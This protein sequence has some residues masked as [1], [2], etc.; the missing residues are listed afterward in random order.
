LVETPSEYCIEELAPEID[1]GLWDNTDDQEYCV[2]AVD[3]LR[4]DCP[5]LDEEDT[6]LILST[7][8]MKSENV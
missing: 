1:F 7:L 6:E 2:E 4:E 8:P 3:I 5:E